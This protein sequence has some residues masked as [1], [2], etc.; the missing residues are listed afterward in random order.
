MSDT[1][2]AQDLDQDPE[3]DPPPTSDVDHEPEGSPPGDGDDEPGTDDPTP[4][5]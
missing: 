4:I 2:D 1:P 5:G 3:T